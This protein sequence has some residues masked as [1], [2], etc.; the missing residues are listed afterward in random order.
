MKS[1]REKLDTH[2]RATHRL[3]RGQIAYASAQ[4]Q[5]AAELMNQA[6][7]LN[8]LD[9]TIR[10]N[11]GVV[12]GLIREGEQEELRQIEQQVQ[13]AMAQNPDDLQ[14]HLHLATVYEMQGEL[15][16]ATRE[17]EEFLRGDPSRS[18]VYLL[19]GPLYERQERYRE[20]L[21]TYER[22]ER[23]E[24]RL[25]APIFAA[26]AQLH[27]QLGN[28]DES[29]KYARKGIAVEPNS[30]RSYLTLG[31]VYAAMNQPQN[32]FNSTKTL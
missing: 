15:G 32:R 19:L 27:L 8:P 7:E 18:D 24:P 22:L 28:L 29:E 23:Q 21:R 5:N 9:E 30:W 13:Q 25:P 31:N 6:V 17:L 10:Y 14:G 1:V 4:Y 20:A 12:S 3:I 11:F 16:K 2:F 26:M